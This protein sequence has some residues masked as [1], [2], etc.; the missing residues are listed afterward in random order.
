MLG[1]MVKARRGAADQAA[2]I[3]YC[4]PVA[5]VTGITSPP[6]PMTGRPAG[7]PSPPVRSR[8]A[9]SM[10][11]LLGYILRPAACHAVGRAGRLQQS[12]DV[13]DVWPRSCRVVTRS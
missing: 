2:L 12:G 10:R 9:G 13:P 3:L 4:R 1:A 8:P 5:P 11:T 7:Q 6:L